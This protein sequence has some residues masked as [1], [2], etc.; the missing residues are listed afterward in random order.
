M[1]IPLVR[2]LAG[3]T[4]LAAASIV[5]LSAPAGAE[6]SSVFQRTATFPVYLNT[7][8]EE[9]TAAEISAVTDDGET[10][11]YTDSPG[12]RLGFV[13]ISDP[14]APKA[15]GILPLDGEP[16]SVAVA[17][18]RI[19]AVVNTSAD[20]V[21]TSGR[22]VVLDADS[23]EVITTVE[24]GGQPDSIA[25]DGGDDFAAIAIENERDEDVDDGDL[26]QA[27]AGFLAVVD[28]ADYSVRDV[29]LTG[30]ADVAADDP[31]PEYVAINARGQAVVTLQENNHIV[32]VDVASAT[33][34][35]DFSAGT[36]TVDGVD[37]VEDGIIDPTG[38][39]TAPREPDAVAWVGDDLI[40]TANEGDWKGGSRGWTVFGTDGRVVADAG[41]SFEHLAITHGLYPEH[42]SENAGAEPEGLTYGVYDGVPYM[43][44]AAERGN[45]VAV[46]D[47]TDPA[48]PRF[49]QILPVTNGPEGLIAVPSRGLFIVSSE[50]DLADDGIRSSV[51]LFK[52]GRG[53]ASFPTIVSDA[54]NGAPIPWGTLSGL[55]ADPADADG[56][57]AV[58]DSAYAQT[59]L[60]GIDVSGEPARITSSIPVTRNGS[61]VGYD[62]EGIFAR[63]GG[64]Y[65]L[66]AEGK[67]SKDVP[68]LL[69]R[70]DGNAV[71][72][73]EIPLPAEV[74]AGMSDNGLE[75]VT[76]TG[77]G[78][79]EVVWVAV[80]RPVD[81][82]DTAR[83]G[84]YAVATGEWTW[85]SYKLESAPE[86][87]TVGLSEIVAV[88]GKT[89]AVVER[90]NQRGTNAAVKRVYTVDVSGVTATATGTPPLAAKKSAID[91]LPVLTAGHGWTQDKL[92]GLAIA[93][94]GRVYAVTDNDAVED[95]TGETVFADLGKATDLFGGKGGGDGDGLATTGANVPMILAV[96]AAVAVLGGGLFVF[97]R[98][99][100]ATLFW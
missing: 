36:A 68:N 22:L 10:L 59:R 29:A 74:A 44:V 92:E 99:R 13:D 82:E 57:F 38:S 25:V 94:N 8:A 30:I 37:T 26:P 12:E 85:L 34:T 91:V 62:G 39:V 4:G 31:E 95:A 93:G 49:T 86:G 61:P 75:G 17:G 73:Q 24:L 7:S 46:Y 53:S 54:P 21:D 52:L 72:Q 63:P 14:A 55:T 60:L 35:G 1:R 66:A 19:L 47:M 45:F 42:R 40:A 67:P 32:F 90:D 11:V 88:D 16:T 71:V 100:K 5:P 84:R 97:A 79:D 23:R 87:V 27:P 15:A 81:G 43:F 18:N 76:A 89:L 48:K 33:V 3:A 98:R 78:A 28:L 80:Q 69:V 58:T 64:G 51:A 2:L 77:T 41:N 83:L 9:E 6:E 56:L 65:W 20:F 50:E 96:A 70:L